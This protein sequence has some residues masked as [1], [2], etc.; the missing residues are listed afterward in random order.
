M[1]PVYFGLG[2]QLYVINSGNS[3]EYKRPGGRLVQYM[4]ALNI[5]LK[6]KEEIK[7]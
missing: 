4:S 2:R 1:L 6:M 5:Y 7:A 3:S